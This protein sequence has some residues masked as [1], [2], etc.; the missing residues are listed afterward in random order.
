MAAAFDEDFLD[1]DGAAMLL[2]EEV[3]FSGAAD[4][5][6]AG[7]ELGAGVA[8]G[9]AI[10]FEPESDAAFLLL[11]FEDFVVAV[12]SALLAVP[13]AGA[14]VSAEAFLLFLDLVEVASEP[15]AAELSADIAS[16]F[17]FFFD[18]LLPAVLSDV[19]AVEESALAAFLLFFEDL[20]F[21]SLPFGAADWSALAASAFFDFFDFLVVE[22][23]VWSAVEL[24]WLCA[25]P[26][27]EQTA[28]IRHKNTQRGVRTIRVFTGCLLSCHTRLS[29]PRKLMRNEGA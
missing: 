8:A 20:V 19:V 16:P 2:P 5:A 24:L 29:N 4:A 7:V 13:A 25:Q 12:V 21:V 14:L 6:G 22:V 27:V 9:A 23:V 18:D 1:A 3:D 26:I 15:E 17:F 10:A 11:F 28:R